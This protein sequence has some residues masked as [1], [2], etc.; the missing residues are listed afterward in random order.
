MTAAGRVL[1]P[2]AYRDEVQPVD[3]SIR[4][5]DPA[6]LAA[7]IA[8]ALVGPERSYREVVPYDDPDAEARIALIRSC[9]RKAG[10]QAG[11]AVQTAAADEEGILR[12][13]SMAIATRAQGREVHVV[14]TGPRP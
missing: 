4:V 14:V 12:L 10:R 2:E 13:G 8:A 7:V 5:E 11:V 3:K 1:G 6:E 9:G